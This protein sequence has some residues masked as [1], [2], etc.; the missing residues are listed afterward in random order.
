MH[1]FGEIVSF[2]TPV[3][4]TCIDETASLFV[5]FNSPGEPREATILSRG[6]LTDGPQSKRKK[7]FAFQRPFTQILGNRLI[8]EVIQCL[9]TGAQT[10][11]GYG[12]CE[13]EMDP[14]CFS[15]DILVSLWR[16]KAPSE[17]DNKLRGTF[18]PLVDSNL[19]TLPPCVDRSRLETVSALG[20]VKIHIQRLAYK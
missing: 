14:N 11:V 1:V 9:R 8:L 13:M 12:Y 17:T 18:T 10:L 4:D 20:K 2:E 16:P 6:T 5:I 15:R 7:V 3:Y 19:V